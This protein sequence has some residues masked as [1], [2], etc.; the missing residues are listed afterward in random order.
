[1]YFLVSLSFIFITE[2]F[3]DFFSFFLSFEIDGIQNEILNFHFLYFLLINYDLIFQQHIYFIQ[4]ISI[5]LH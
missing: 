4:N 5:I 1:M 2:G 3:V